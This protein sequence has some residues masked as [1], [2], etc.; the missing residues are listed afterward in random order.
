[1]L[2]FLRIFLKYLSSFIKK[3][4]VDDDDDYLEFEEAE[5]M[6]ASRHICIVESV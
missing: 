5:D 2:S 3:Q 6:D 1:M 4:K